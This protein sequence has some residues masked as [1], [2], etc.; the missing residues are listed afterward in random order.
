VGGCIR[1]IGWIEL[2]L[3]GSGLGILAEYSESGDELGLRGSRKLVPFSV[4]LSSWSS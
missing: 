3:N 2:D 4:I 1:V